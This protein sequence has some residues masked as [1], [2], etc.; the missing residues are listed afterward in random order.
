MTTSGYSPKILHADPEHGG[1]RF[2]VIVILIF[3]LILSFILFQL[4]LSLLAADTILI[5]FTNV[6][7]CGGA[8]L[9]ALLLAYAAETYLKRTWPSGTMLTLGDTELGCKIRGREPS[10]EPEEFLFDWSKN[11]NLTRWYFELG[12]YPRAGRERRVSGKWVCLACRL[13]QDDAQLI[14]FGYFPPDKA[15]V[16]TADQNLSEPF[17]E[18]SLAFLYAEAGK[19]RRGAGTRPAVPSSMLTG[20]D[21]RYWLAEQKRWKD[22]VELTQEDFETFMEYMERKRQIG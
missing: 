16:W 6:I 4:L 10:Q 9:L 17:R 7:S 21:G 20:K 8:I 18:I 2:A 12:G 19:K 22:G 15:A 1:L 11:L 13:Q 14:T 5:E 3:G